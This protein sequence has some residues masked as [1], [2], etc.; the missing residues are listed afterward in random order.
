M[1]RPLHDPTDELNKNEA[2]RWS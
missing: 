2:M 1:H